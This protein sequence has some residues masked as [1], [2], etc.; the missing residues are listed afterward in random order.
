[1][2]GEAGLRETTVVT[3]QDTTDTTDPRIGEMQSQIAE[4][5]KRVRLLER[6]TTALLEEHEVDFQHIRAAVMERLEEE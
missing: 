4:L 1:V 5:T 6:G 2:R 3:S